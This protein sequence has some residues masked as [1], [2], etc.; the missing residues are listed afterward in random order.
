VHLTT[1]TRTSTLDWD[2]IILHI[3]AFKLSPFRPI[4]IDDYTLMTAETCLS[5]LNHQMSDDY[6]SG[7]AASS[8]KHVDGGLPCRQTTGPGNSDKST[9]PD[10]P[11]IS[12]GQVAGSAIRQPI[13]SGRPRVSS[14]PLLLDALV[15]L[16]VPHGL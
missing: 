7:G 15:K 8:D 6:L 16:S 9:T 5:L 3:H 12:D 13:V 4:N 14:L 2:S 10:G 11:G 1:F